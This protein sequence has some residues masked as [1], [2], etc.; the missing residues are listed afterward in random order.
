MNYE[1]QIKKSKNGGY[2]IIETMISVSLFIIIV[3]IALGSLL[4]T[5]LLHKKSQNMRSLMDNLSF[6]ME[7][8]SRNL[9]TG[10]NYHCISGSDSVGVDM[11]SSV[12]KSGS[13]CWGI[14]FKTSSGS[15]QW[16]YEVV[17]MSGSTY[18]IKSTDNGSTWV[19]LTPKEIDITSASFTITGAEPPTYNPDGTLNMSG[20]L[21]QPFVTIKLVGSITSNGVTSPFSLQTSVSQRRID[22]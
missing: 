14:A 15:S 1:L 20:N 7:D 9:R 4:N 21:L 13:N 10:Y 16:G 12:A 22:I 11:G 18:I 17:T 5:N 19:Q 2:T 3:T 8:M 6:V